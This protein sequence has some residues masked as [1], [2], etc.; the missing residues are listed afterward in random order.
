[1]GSL[2]NTIDTRINIY[3]S[4]YLSIYISNYLSMR[5]S[6]DQLF[7]LSIFYIYPA[8]HFLYITICSS[9][10]IQD[11]RNIHIYICIYTCVSEHNFKFEINV[12]DYLVQPFYHFFSILP[13]YICIYLLIFSH[14]ITSN[15][16]GTVGLS[17][18]YKQ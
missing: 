13:W 8:N 3:L 10:F 11:H 14:E 1:M 12:H 4:I 16:L 15:N 6:I 5:I 17:R 18:N 7:Y 2:I 9:S